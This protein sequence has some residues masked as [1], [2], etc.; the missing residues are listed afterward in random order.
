METPVDWQ[1]SETGREGSQSRIDSKKVRTVG[2]IDP[3][4]KP[5]EAGLNKYFRVILCK[6]EEAVFFCTPFLTPKVEVAPEGG[7]INSLA[8]SAC[9]CKVRTGFMAREGPQAKRC[10]CRLLEDEPLSG[11]QPG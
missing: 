11:K 4:E 7:S 1:R 3:S 2:H 8:L 6:N 5:W 9:L 10:K